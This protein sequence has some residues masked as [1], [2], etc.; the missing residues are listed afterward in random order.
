M[1]ILVSHEKAKEIYSL[2]C[3]N[4]I[5][6]NLWNYSKLNAHIDLYNESDPQRIEDTSFIL[7]WFSCMREHGETYILLN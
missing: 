6:K 2:K 4:N 1:K 5:W 7:L 3:W